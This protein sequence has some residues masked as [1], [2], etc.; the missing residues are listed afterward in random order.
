MTRWRRAIVG[1][2]ILAGALL[3]ANAVVNALQH[4]H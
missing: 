1:L 4:S 3:W 2:S